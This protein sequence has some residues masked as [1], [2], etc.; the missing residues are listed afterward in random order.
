M[1]RR[2]LS[3]SLIP[4]GRRR[5]AAG[6]AQSRH[7]GSRHHRHSATSDTSGE[8]LQERGRRASSRAAQPDDSACSTRPAEG[9]H[10]VRRAVG[11]RVT[12]C[13]NT[14]SDIP[15]EDD[16]HG[17]PAHAEC[18]PVGPA[19]L[20]ARS[21]SGGGR[22]HFVVPTVPLKRRHR[23]TLALLFEHPTPA[24]IPWRDRPH[25]GPDTDKGAVASIR[26]WLRHNGVEP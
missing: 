8:A 14:A 4:D 7:P 26:D 13:R 9:L 18:E 6:R 22:Y 21:L 1:G 3:R 20:A 17:R 10:P 16:G 15:F 24:N 25:P 2:R 23:R 12:N 11:R 5:G 19:I